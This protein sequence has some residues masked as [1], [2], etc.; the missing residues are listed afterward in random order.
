MTLIPGPKPPIPTEASPNEFLSALVCK[1]IEA[2]PFWFDVQVFERFD[3]V[4]DGPSAK[5]Y[6]PS[7]KEAFTVTIVVI[8]RGIDSL[9]HAHMHDDNDTL[10]DEKTGQKLFVSKEERSVV[11]NANLNN[12]ITIVTDKAALMVLQV[13]LFGQVVF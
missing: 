7:E 9:L 13:A 1:A 5:I 3:H 2:K 4:I 11:F 12:D 6:V 10:Q 8:R